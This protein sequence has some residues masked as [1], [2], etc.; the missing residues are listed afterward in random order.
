MQDRTTFGSF[1]AQ[2]VSRAA[3]NPSD[4]FYSTIAP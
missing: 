2:A 4:V 3:D 1:F